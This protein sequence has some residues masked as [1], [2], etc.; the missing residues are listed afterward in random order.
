MRYGSRVFL[1]GVLGLAL[2]M[3][4]GCS[5]A[6]APT[7]F[8]HVA[9]LD[10]GKCHTAEQALWSSPQDLH[11]ASADAIL[12]SA[13]HNKAE[14]PKDDCL[15]CHAM[16]QAVSLHATVDP[17]GKTPGTKIPKSAYGPVDDPSQ[18]YYSA[19][20]THFVSPASAKGPWKVTNQADWQATR[21]EVCHQ[22]SSTA[23]Y[24]LAK[25]GAWL[26]SQPSSAYIQL[27]TGMPVAYDYVLGNHG[28][29]KHTYSEQAA[30][31]VH[32][33][34]L[35]DSCHDPDDQGGDPAKIIHGRNYGPQGGDSRAYVTANH[36]ELACVDCH[37]RHDFVPVTADQ[38]EDD[39]RCIGLGCHNERVPA[40]KHPTD[41]GV[42]HTNHIP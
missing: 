9:G 26:D 16:F 14:V 27:D 17:T 11:S 13:D 4:Q 15:L 36:A 19:A 6:P 31:T 21:C 1:A 22:P 33:T 34:K 12:G 5:A 23:M 18:S 7:P 2:A 10:C 3:V 37:Q 25:Y 30:I 40:P 20:I 35:C 32:A 8:V 24:K 28:Y 38:A 39:P 29:V 41:P 42:V